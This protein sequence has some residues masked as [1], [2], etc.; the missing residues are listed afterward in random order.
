MNN[1]CE[2]FLFIEKKRPIHEQT[3][4]EL[5]E[6]IPH[7][8]KNVKELQKRYEKKTK[9]KIPKVKAPTKRRKS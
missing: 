4:E 8:I 3:I 6:T 7:I 5:S 2:Y 9:I 1:D